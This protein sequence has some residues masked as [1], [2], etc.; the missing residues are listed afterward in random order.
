VRRLDG[1]ASEPIPGTEGGYFPFFSPDGRQVGFFVAGWV[2]RVNLVGGLPEAVMPA[3]GAITG[4]VW[5][6]D[7]TI[8]FTTNSSGVPQRVDPTRG[9]SAPIEVHGPQ[10]A[11]GV[12][13]H[14]PRLL[15]D[16]RTL[17]LTARG[18]A[19]NVPDVV[20]LD[21][22]SGEWT[23]LVRGGSDALF[24]APDRLL[25][26]QQEQLM[27]TGFDPA[28]LAV[29]GDAR[30]AGLDAPAIDETEGLG[31][32]VAGLSEGGLLVYPA[33]GFSQSSD[34]LRVGADGEVTPTGLTG[35]APRVD[36]TG[37]RA[38]AV[39]RDSV[40]RVLDLESG[41]D[42]PLTF[43]STSWYPLWSHDDARILFSDR[44]DSGWKTWTVSPDGS[45]GAEIYL[46][47]LSDTI[48]TDVARD[49]TLMGYRV[50]PE[51]SRDVWIRGPDGEVRM[52]LE[53]AA[54]ERVPAIAP[55]GRFFA[56]LSNEE[57]ADQVYLRDLS[58]LERRW[59]LSSEGGVS[60]VWSRGGRELYFRRGDSIVAVEVRTG[61]GVRVGAERVVYT[62]DRLDLDV[63]GNR[64]FDSL[65]DGGL[66]VS[67]REES[68][69]VLRVVVGWGGAGR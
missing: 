22:E 51:T 25:Y 56:Y 41:S 23:T 63:W 55:D 34:I 62:N 32:F 17:L 57:G 3:I 4:A 7:N 39:D 64:T 29:F 10:L 31:V 40:V 28:K 35:I 38:V 11:P 19:P 65:P 50:D 30:P 8:L 46:E 2:K 47:E 5:A 16:G 67:V 37:R 15:P 6:A 42:T 43:L 66:L 1:H 26:V 18:A 14:G 69:V 33:G 60:P 61:G 12:G 21:M 44:R 48:T 59:Q 54:N 53:T 68:D 24:A 49:G 20:A 13:L 27:V 9:E 36:S 52:L 58:A 45:S